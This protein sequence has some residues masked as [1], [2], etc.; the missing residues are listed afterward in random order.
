MLRPLTWLISLAL[1]S[2]IALVFLMPAG[3]AALEKGSGQDAMIVEQGI[4]LEGLAKLGADEAS[5][6]AVEATP[7]EA[8]AATPPEEVQ[9][10]EDAKVIASTEGLKQDVPFE[11]KP[12]EIKPVPPQ[13]VVQPRPE[14][15]QPLPRQRVATLQQ[16]TTVEQHQSS[17]KALLGG[18]TTTRSAYL[19]TL[20]SRLERAKINPRSGIS[21]TAVVDFVVDANGRVISREV[22]VSS[23]HKVLDDAAL[24]SI[25]KA[26]P[27]PPM[28][29]TLNQ[30]KI[31]VSVPFKFSVR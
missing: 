31:E 25:D 9:P 15:V 13:P 16:E 17:G 19:G 7:A 14:Q 5:V 26:S 21:G 8:A 3:N 11:P 4:A 1:H 29:K 10:V 24:A 18:D 28:P 23:G 12:E 2:A 30:A 22:R 6:K 27:F 20:R